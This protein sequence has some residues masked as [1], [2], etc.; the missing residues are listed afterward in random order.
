MNMDEI[1]WTSTWTIEVKDVQTRLRIGIW[2]HERDFQP[3]IVN[4][5]L[6]GNAPIFPETIED[7]ID[8]EPICRWLIDELPN[9]PHTPL[10]ETKLAEVLHFVFERDLRINWADVA[11]SKPTA[12][13]NVGSAGVRL[14]ISRADYAATLGGRRTEEMAAVLEAK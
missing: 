7:C 3:V 13:A 12:I 2:E 9:R 8:Y 11:M 1:C 4:I 14:A 6:R 10:L 5:T